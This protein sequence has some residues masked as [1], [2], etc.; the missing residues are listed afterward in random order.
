M[1]FTKSVAMLYSTMLVLLLLFAATL[2]SASTHL[3]IGFYKATCPSAET[4]VRKAVNKAVSRNPG[5]AAG[6]IRMHFHD[7]FVRVSTIHTDLH[8][9]IYVVYGFVL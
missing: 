6:L 8:T 7:C 4:I 5:I 3:K 2:A 9:H 1:G